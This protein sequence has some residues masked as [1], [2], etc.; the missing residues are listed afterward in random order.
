M[1]KYAQWVWSMK[2]LP[3]PTVA[4][5]THAMQTFSAIQVGYIKLLYI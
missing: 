2:G 3:V 5:E 4:L 1:L